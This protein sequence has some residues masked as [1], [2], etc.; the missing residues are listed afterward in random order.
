M[1]CLLQVKTID[2]PWADDI[3]A[4]LDGILRSKLGKIYMLITINIMAELPEHT[5]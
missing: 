5:V 2:P 3:V 4:G 1:C